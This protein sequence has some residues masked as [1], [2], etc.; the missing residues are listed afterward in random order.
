MD[1]PLAPPYIPPPSP[2][3]PPPPPPPPLPRRRRPPPWSPLRPPPPPLPRRSSEPLHPCR[4]APDSGRR[5]RRPRRRCSC[6]RPPSLPRDDIRGNRGSEGEGR[7]EQEG[8]SQV[9]RED[10]RRPADQPPLP[11]D[12]PPQAPQEQRPPLHGQEVLQAPGSGDAAAAPPPPAAPEG[13]DAKRRRGRPPKAKLEG[14]AAPVAAA[15]AGAAAAELVPASQGPDGGPAPITV[16]VPGDV[17]AKRGRGRPPKSGGLAKSRVGRPLKPSMVA[18]L[19]NGMQN[20][21]KPRGRPRK[22]IGGVADVASTG[23]AVAVFGKRRGRPPGSGRGK[24]PGVAPQPRKSTGRP[25]GRPR[26]NAAFGASLAAGSNDDFRRTLEYIQSK[27]KEAVSVLRP[28]LTSSISA[29]DAIQELEAIT[30]M[31]FAAVPVVASSSVAPS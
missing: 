16:P 19:A 26:K 24:R 1:P 27:I 31:D 5:P 7:V 22:N 30:T 6:S 10:L 29:V 20:G 15:A 18:V 17:P 2:P 14:L 25:M 3:P 28:H 13:S 11:A 12:P 4:R 21:P 23:E 9:H 8:H